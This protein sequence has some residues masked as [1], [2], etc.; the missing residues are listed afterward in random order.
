MF[1]WMGFGLLGVG[2][3]FFIDIIDSF[4]VFLGGVFY[5]VCMFDV[6]FVIFD[7]IVYLVWELCGELWVQLS[8]NY[9]MCY[10]FVV[11]F[12]EGEI[13]VVGVVMSE[14]VEVML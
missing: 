9:M 1:Q 8:K 6:L 13:C 4:V 2:L 7:V 3:I 10:L 14:D 5:F 11:V 12:V